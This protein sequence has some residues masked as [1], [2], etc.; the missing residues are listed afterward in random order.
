MSEYRVSTTATLPSGPN[1]LGGRLVEVAQLDHRRGRAKL[2]SLVGRLRTIDTL[3]VANTAC[4]RSCFVV[5]PLAFPKNLT[6]ARRL[7]L[8]RDGE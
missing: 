6:P 4:S 2:I 5:S 1:G 8:D 3:D 7:E